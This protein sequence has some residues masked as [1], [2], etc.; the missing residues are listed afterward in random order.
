MDKIF[1]PEKYGM[2]FC[3]NCNGKGKLSKNPGGFNVC[4]R[5]G[6]GGV[7]KKEKELPKKI[8]NKKN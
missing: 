8:E 5:C 6:G 1:D 2:L 7:I 4:L 3:P